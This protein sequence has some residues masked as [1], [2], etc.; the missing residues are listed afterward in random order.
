MAHLR[1]L[2]RIQRETRGFTEFV[3][4]PIP[5]WGRPL[6]EGRA[7]IDE[8]RA[9]VA[10]SRLMLTG[11]IPHIQLPWTRLGLDQTRELLNAGGDDGGTLRDGR[12]GPLS[13]I[14]AGQE[15]TLDAA[16]ALVKPLF[17]PLRHRTTTYGEVGSA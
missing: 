1:E 13:G 14:E 9:M 6:V 2:I 7:A 5:G 17:R 10:V 15:L 16:R 12:V 11:L 4:I 8:H 3:P